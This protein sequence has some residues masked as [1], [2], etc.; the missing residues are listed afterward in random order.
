MPLMISLLLCFNR[1]QLN[2]KWACLHL[3]AP[4]CSIAVFAAGPQLQEAAA[5]RAL[6]TALLEESG[7]YWRGSVQ[8]MSSAWAM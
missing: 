2:F 1:T 5:L 8:G 3:V 4:M 6:G 7:G